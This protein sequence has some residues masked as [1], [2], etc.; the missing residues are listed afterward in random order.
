MPKA[1]MHAL[2]QLIRTA[3]MGRMG[4]SWGSGFP[5]QSHPLQMHLPDTDFQ[6]SA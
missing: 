5:T 4:Q 3:T 2:A 1:N 6:S